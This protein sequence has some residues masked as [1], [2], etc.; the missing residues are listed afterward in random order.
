[1]EQSKPPDANNFTIYNLYVLTDYSAEWLWL[2]KDCA[3]NNLTIYVPLP[4]PL[5]EGEDAKCPSY[6][7]LIPKRCPA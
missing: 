7:I 5:P 6:F 1:V 2:D 4:Q 3:W